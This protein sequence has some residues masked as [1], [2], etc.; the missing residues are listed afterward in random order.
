[1]LNSEIIKNLYCG[2]AEYWEAHRDEFDY[3]IHACKEPYHR[4]ALG[5]KGRGAPRES[6]E[7]LVAYRK[8]EMCLNLIDAD[9][10]K[11]IPLNLMIEAVDVIR[12]QLE[13]GKHVFVHCNEGKSRG[14]AIVFLYLMFER[15]IR[16]ETYDKSVQL[17]KEAYPLFEPGKGVDGFLRN[18]FEIYD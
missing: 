6:S 1:M 10:P 14:P 18:A 5:Y 4:K 3:V 9:D 7:Y 2:D 13:S 16:E 11:Y 17:F 15:V 12:D 8:N